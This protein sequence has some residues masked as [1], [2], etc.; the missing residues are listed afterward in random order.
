ME[1]LSSWIKKELF[2]GLGLASGKDIPMRP[3]EDVHYFNCGQGL[4]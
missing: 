3:A 1:A 2:R 4:Q